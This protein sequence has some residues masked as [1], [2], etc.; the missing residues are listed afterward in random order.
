MLSVKES[1][2]IQENNPVFVSFIQKSAESGLPE[3]QFKLFQLYSKGIGTEKNGKLA[4]DWLNRS[5][6]NGYPE[7]VQFIADRD[8]KQDGAILNGKVKS[9]E[10]LAYLNG[11]LFT[12]C[13]EEYNQEG[14]IS[15]VENYKDGKKYGLTTVFHESTHKKLEENY[16]EGK[17]DGP[18]TEWDKNG[19]VVRELFFKE[20]NPVEIDSIKEQGTEELRANKEKES[21]HNHTSSG[22][23]QLSRSKDTNDPPKED[24]SNISSTIDSANWSSEESEKQLAF[25]DSQ[26]QNFY[27]NISKPPDQLLAEVK[28]NKFE[29]SLDKLKSGLIDEDT[30]KLINENLLNL[31]NLRRNLKPRLSS[32]TNTPRPQAVP[33]LKKHST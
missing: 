30:F 6:Q 26:L 27:Q 17:K 11:K 22:P 3:S 18:S 8:G 2:S 10:N 32:L 9:Q 31:E 19:K 7:A 14:Q 16:K 29:H 12:G 15:F 20:G 21:S 25:L 28:S 4:E 23:D 24:Y 13:A 1:L 33:L 5:F